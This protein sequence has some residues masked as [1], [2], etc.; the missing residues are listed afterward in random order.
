MKHTILLAV[1]SQENL[2]PFMEASDGLLSKSIQKRFK[3][4]FL[5]EV[6]QKQTVTVQASEQGRIDRL[7]SRVENDLLVEKYARERGYAVELL[8]EVE[9]ELT[10]QSQ[11]S[12]AD[13]II[14]DFDF[15]DKL[16]SYNLIKEAFSQADCPKLLLFPN[17]MSF[18]CLVAVHYASK[19][20]VRVLKDFLKLFDESFTK[21]PFSLLMDEPRGELEMKR[22]RVFINYLKLFFED[23]GAQHIYDEPLDSLLN[24]IRNECENPLLMVNSELGQE[25]MESDEFLNSPMP[26]HPIFISKD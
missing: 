7:V 2:I 18:N 14:I 12:V 8:H 26:N 1:A 13:L 3:V 24:F 17:G 25:I 4:V 6:L 19:A 15:P 16:T 23:M 20:S 9:D 10:L 21:L 5:D 11:C 22:E